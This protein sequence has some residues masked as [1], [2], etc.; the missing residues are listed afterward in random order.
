VASKEIRKPSVI[1]TQVVENSGDEEV[2]MLAIAPTS[3]I[4]RMPS[5]TWERSDPDVLNALGEKIAKLSA[6]LNADSYR[7]LALIAEFDRLEGWKREG[8]ASCAAG[9][10]TARSSTR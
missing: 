8:F 9:S 5:E 2:E 10:P 7:L 4:R 3:V 1:F 6:R